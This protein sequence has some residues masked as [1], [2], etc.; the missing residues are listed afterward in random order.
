MSQ[1]LVNDVVI[2][3]IILIAAFG[4]SNSDSFIWG[5][6]FL[7][8]GVLA[9]Y[10]QIANAR[11]NTRREEEQIAGEQRKQLE[12][13]YAIRRHAKRVIQEHTRTLSRKRRHGIAV[14]DY[15]IQHTSKW[16][17]EKQYFYENV[18]YPVIKDQL[19]VMNYSQR[20]AFEEYVDKEIEL[21]AQNT[22]AS[23][24]I[25]VDSIEDLTPLEFELYCADRLKEAGWKARTTQGSGDQGVDVLAEKD[26][27]LVVLQ[28]K[29][30]SNPVGNK[31]VQEVFTGKHHY[32]AD[33]AV[34]VTNNDFTSSAKQLAKTTGVHLIHYSQLSGLDSLLEL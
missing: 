27:C 12:T 32:D 15:G 9:R 22:Y 21:I 30:Y 13:E 5:F 16:N 25:N 8:L 2:G 23:S 4:G 31:A 18:L 24:D 19:E 34:V 1:S 26:G 14:D 10:G 28:A 3:T 7:V 11:A 17:G 20:S 33:H 29:M 6:A